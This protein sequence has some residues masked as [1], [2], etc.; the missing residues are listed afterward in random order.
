M[1]ATAED[2]FFEEDEDDGPSALQQMDE[3]LTQMRAL[4]EG[5][6]K[7]TSLVEERDRAAEAEHARLQSSLLSSVK[8]L[9]GQ[10]ANG[11][12]DA[13]AQ[14]LSDAWKTGPACG[15]AAARAQA[16]STLSTA[17]GQGT[18]GSAERLEACAAQAKAAAEFRT[19]DAAMSCPA[20]SPPVC[21]E[22]SR[23][24]R[25]GTAAGL[26][27]NGAKTGDGVVADAVS[28]VSRLAS[29]PLLPPSEA[30]APRSGRARGVIGAGG[31]SGSAAIRGRVR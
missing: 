28:S 15:E 10:V 5:L 7:E 27:V 9:M 19:P 16:A 24:A 20:A 23:S 30:S 4:R 22:Q 13:L 17:C 31:T 21:A 2:L 12:C 11:E 18:R 6:L 8:A 29:R 3:T 26:H 14:A 25:K 1:A